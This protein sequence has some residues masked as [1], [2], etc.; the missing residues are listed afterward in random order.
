MN[1]VLF[2]AKPPGHTCP[3]IDEARTAIRRLA[4]MADDPGSSAALSAALTALE[5]VRAENTELRQVYIDAMA[6]R[7]IAAEVIH[8]VHSGYDGPM[9]GEAVAPL[10]RALATYEARVAR[11]AR[12]A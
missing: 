12:T 2:P 11:R 5:R 9:R 4:R 8:L 3:G 7:H 10:Y 1:D 6:F